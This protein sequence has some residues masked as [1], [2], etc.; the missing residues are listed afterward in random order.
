MYTNTLYTFVTALLLSIGA[1]SA[2]AQ[3]PE[4]PSPE[5]VQIK[6]A[7]SFDFT[8]PFGLV[9]G[10]TTCAELA[11]CLQKRIWDRS[12]EG[13][14]FNAV[15]YVS[16]D[17]QWYGWV[18]AINSCSSP[19]DTI[20]NMDVIFISVNTNQ[21]DGSALRGLLSA[22]ADRLTTKG[23][24][25]KL[26]YKNV[27]GPI[28]PRVVVYNSSASV[29]VKV[30]RD[31]VSVAFRSHRFDPSRQAEINRAPVRPIGVAVGIS[32]CYEA[33]IEIDGKTSL[34][35]NEHKTNFQGVPITIAMDSIEVAAKNPGRL[36]PGATSIEARCDNLDDRVETFSV[37]VKD[38][39]SNSAAQDA[40]RVLASKYKRVEGAQIPEKGT[41]YAR[42]EASG[43]TIELRAWG[44]GQDFLMEYMESQVFEMIKKFRDQKR[45]AL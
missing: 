13:G 26:L 29:S 17:S 30:E 3:L 9:F 25:W 6:P 7:T 18:K 12:P 2:V 40:Y 41:G 11:A 15:S 43:V 23:S 21:S 44:D 4:T 5:Y 35:R 22:F 37:S 32:T 10:R 16:Y 45:Q 14:S 36:Y 31:F 39:P 19:H 20:E 8:N 28:S 38:R 1:T 24:D 27:N 33:S 34:K 42:F